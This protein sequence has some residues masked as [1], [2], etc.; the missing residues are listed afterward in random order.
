MATCHTGPRGADLSQPVRIAFVTEVWHPTVNGVVTRLDATVEQLCSMGHDVL[1]IAPGIGDVDVDDGN[2]TVRGVPTISLPW[3]Y[4]GQPWGL[5]LPRV[6]RYLADFRPDLVHVAN[7]ACLGVAGVFYARRQ[8]LPLVCSYHTDLTAYATFYHLG[9]LRPVIGCTLRALHRRADLN[10]VTSAAAALQLSA[11]G[12]DGARLWTQGVDSRRFHPGPERAEPAPARHGSAGPERAGPEAGHEWPDRSLT[13]L[14]VGRLAA[15]KRL[16]A[17]APLAAIDGLHLVVVGDGPARVEAASALAG[18]DVEFTGVLEGDALARAYRQADVFVFPSETETLGLVL[19]EALASGL[20][21]VAADS[22]ASREVLAGCRAARRWD[23]RDPAGLPAAV[24]ELLGSAERATLRRLARAQVEAASWQRATVD[25]VARY[26][27]ALATAQLSGRR[28]AR[29]R[30]H[31]GRFVAVG[32]SNAAIDLGVF[33]ALAALGPTQRPAQLAAYNTVAVA[34][35]LANSY[36]WNSRWTFKR[37]RGRQWRWSATRRRV[38]FI[39]QGILNLFVND[40]AVVVAATVLNRSGVLP[41]VAVTNG[42]KVVGMVTASLTSFAFM[43][44]V[45]F[46][47]RAKAVGPGPPDGHQSLR[48]VSVR[49]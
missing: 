25:L 45:V 3:I 13:A 2:L 24:G 43:R 16:A 8:R 9:W 6:G 40:L 38:L 41:P 32:A 4:G 33:N 22:P 39:L 23:P 26:R 12:I 29:R 5:P 18:L 36:W 1:V 42:S 7:P 27:T 28:Q 31:F 17:L 21:V 44:G 35:A 10:L 15:E 37:E 34:L 20:P 48:R 11:E 30:R 19:L 47:H 49:R 46:R 14:Y